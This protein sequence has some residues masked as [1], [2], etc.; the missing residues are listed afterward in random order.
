MKWLIRTELV[1]GDT[2]VLGVERISAREIGIKLGNARTRPRVAPVVRGVA[3]D[4]LVQGS[5]V[6]MLYLADLLN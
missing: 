2:N 4:M 1:R 3:I 6:S 5:M